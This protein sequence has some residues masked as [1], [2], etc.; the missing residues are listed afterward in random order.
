VL[1]TLLDPNSPTSEDE[2][3]HL[4]VCPIPGI[5]KLFPRIQNRRIPAA[6]Q[7][8]QGRT[9]L[10]VANPRFDCSVLQVR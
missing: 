2:I 4:L 6:L 1:E 3:N 7:D 8:L 5:G 10:K 9:N